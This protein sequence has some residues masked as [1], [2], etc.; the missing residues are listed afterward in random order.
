MGQDCGAGERYCTTF[1]VALPPACAR[2]GDAIDAWQHGVVSHLRCRGRAR[3]ARGWIGAGS[4]RAA[5][6]L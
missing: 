1:A 5:A 2:I 4:G 3:R 6:E